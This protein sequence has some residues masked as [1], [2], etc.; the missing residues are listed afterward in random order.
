MG[1]SRG[2]DIRPPVFDSRRENHTNTVSKPR[3]G[4]TPPQALRGT[5]RLELIS[6]G[7]G[8]DEEAIGG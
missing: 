8:N 1:F 5:C 3:G 2:F 6:G 4:A 7:G